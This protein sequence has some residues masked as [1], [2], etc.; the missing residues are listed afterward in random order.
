MAAG[1]LRVAVAGFGFRFGFAGARGCGL[2]GG[3]AVSGC[4]VDGCGLAGV[5]AGRDAPALVLRMEATSLS[6]VLSLVVI[7]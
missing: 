3:A 5:D 7:N 2:A 4:A 1:L 6:P